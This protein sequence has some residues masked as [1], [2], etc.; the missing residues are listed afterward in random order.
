MGKERTGVMTAPAVLAAL[1]A[2]AVSSA[3]PLRVVRAI[4]TLRGTGKCATSAASLARLRQN[5]EA[6]HAAS[7]TA[8]IR[9]ESALHDALQGLVSGQPK[10]TARALGRANELARAAGQALPS[11]LMADIDT[12]A[13]T[14]AHSASGD[15]GALRPSRVK[16]LSLTV[17]VRRQRHHKLRGADVVWADYSGLRQDYPALRALTDAQIDAWI[18]D[19]F[20]YISEKQLRLAGIRTSKI[21]V[22]A[23]GTTTLA[24]PGDYYRASVA[25]AKFGDEPLGLMDLKG[26]GTSTPRDMEGSVADQIKEFEQAAGDAAKLDALRTSGYSDGVVTL[27]EAIAEVTRELGTRLAVKILGAQTGETIL[28]VES[29]FIIRAPFRILRDGDNTVGAAIYGRT[30]QWRQG[31]NADY[32]EGTPWPQIFTSDVGAQLSTFDEIIDFGAMKI[33]WPS[34]RNRFGMLDE[35]AAWNTQ[36]GAKPWVYG[37]ETATATQGRSLSDT[38]DIINRH[39]DDMIRPLREEWETML[40]QGVAPGPQHLEQVLRSLARPAQG[41][42]IDWKLR[43]RMKRLALQQYVIPQLL[44]NGASNMLARLIVDTGSSAAVFKDLRVSAANVQATL[45]LVVQVLERGAPLHDET[46]ALLRRLIRKTS[47]TTSD[48]RARL[49]ALRQQVSTARDSGRINES[50]ANELLG[51]ITGRIGTP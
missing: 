46:A 23:S 33:E 30:P 42:G 22:E 14:A 2:P 38:R 18:L 39:I 45:D 20:A 1:C 26:T 6:I 19:N 50:A 3:Q 51:R 15:L 8:G 48:G 40:A 31:E 21:P 36:E 24:H 12:A 9:V 35:S 16:D 7:P 27:G 13:L 47:P 41:K 11:E 4:E 28:T 44:E 17:K 5:L 32:V 49:E 25:Q 34:V 10:V 43:Q 37:S 29:R